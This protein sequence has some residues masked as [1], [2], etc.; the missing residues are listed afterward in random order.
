LHRN[1]ATGTEG[2]HGSCSAPRIL[3]ALMPAASLIARQH[4]C[5]H[6]LR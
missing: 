4:V 1:D 2:R 6:R 5:H 3:G